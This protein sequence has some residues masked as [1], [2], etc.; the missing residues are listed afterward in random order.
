[1]Y[2]MPFQRSF[3]RRT[4]QRR[5]GRSLFSSDKGKWYNFVKDVKETDSKGDVSLNVFGEFAED[6]DTARPFYPK[7]MWDKL[8]QDAGEGANRAVDIAAGTG[9]GCLELAR[10]NFDATAIDLDQGMLNK[11]KTNAEAEGLKISTIKAPAESTKL[12]DNSIDVLVCLQAFHWFE[13]EK[14]VAEFHRI[15]KK[16]NG[17][18]VVAWN[19]RDLSVP[20]VEELEG[21]F[22]KHNPLYNR[23]LKLAE[24]VVDYGNKFTETGHF[25]MD[26]LQ[27][28]PNPTKSMTVDKLIELVWTF[29]Y[30]RAPFQDRHEDQAADFEEELKS[31]V[32]SHHGDAPFDLP[33]VCKAYTLRPKI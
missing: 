11:V 14:A 26:S 6:Y 10:R 31:L 7:E 13:A 5:L 4:L 32:Q 12:K 2:L 1:M 21:V 33:W 24:Y 25:H 22:E 8:M 18:A 3:L 28:Y 23:D 19:D 29:S 15:L 16:E 30:V 17:I 9:R 20:W 27:F